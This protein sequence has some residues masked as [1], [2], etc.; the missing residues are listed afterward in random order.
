M[1]LDHF[2][3][4]GSALGCHTGRFPRDVFDSC[5]KT[6]PSAQGLKEAIDNDVSEKTSGALSIAAVPSSQ[7]LSV[8]QK[9]MERCKR[10]WSRIRVA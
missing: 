4:Q 6:L 9:L 5:E 10:R 1:L 3:R 7:P 2:P 8:L